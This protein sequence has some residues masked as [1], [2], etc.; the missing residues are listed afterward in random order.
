M[1]LRQAQGH[2][3]KFELMDKL[4]IVLFDIDY[5]L[6][7]SRNFRMKIM[8]EI[9]EKIKKNKTEDIE[10][11]LDRIYF[12]SRKKMGF[13]STSSFIKDVNKKFST[14]IPEDFLDQYA[15][16]KELHE[17]L[18][19]EVEKILEDI[20]KDR[21]LTIGIFSGGDQVFQREKIRKL[22]NFFQEK[23]IHIF[24]YKIDELKSV[25]MKYKDYKVFLIDDVLPILS[26]AKEIN[27]EIFTIWV[28]RGKFADSQAIDKKLSPDLEVKNLKNIISV[29]LKS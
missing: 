5:T 4:K 12:E 16:S 6:F 10:E 21:D 25:L 1:T 29:I 8:R 28:R 24:P 11:T 27:K 22:I 15:R 19:D 17:H 18:Y 9:A 23:H 20:T 2:S 26:K 7:D 3:E 13:F 14:K